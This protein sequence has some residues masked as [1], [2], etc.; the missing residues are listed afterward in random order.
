MLLREDK[1]MDDWLTDSHNI[2]DIIH[3]V[4]PYNGLEAKIIGSATFARLQR[5][6]QSSLAY[7]IY[8]S[9]KV[10]RYEHSIGVMYL[11]GK[12]F[13]HSISNSDEKDVNRLFDEIYK[14]LLNWVDK[15]A[16][17]LTDEVVTDVKNNLDE[18][19]KPSEKVEFK[20]ID[21]R[22]YCEN[23]PSNLAVNQL[24]L[25]YMTYE[26]IR[27]SGL[28]H[29]IGHLPYSHITEF[30]LKRLYVE[31]NDYLKEGNKTNSRI[32]EFIRV[33][34]PYCDKNT[35]KQIHEEV[36][37]KL[38]NKLF[39][40]VMDYIP[41]KGATRENL[42]LAGVFHLTEAILKSEPKDNNILSDLH[43]IID[44]VIDC[45]RMDYCC[46]DLYCAGISKEL[47]RYERIF[48]TVKLF[49]K[50][51]QADKE[52]DNKENNERERCNFS[53]NS[54]ALGQIEMLL[55]SRWEDFSTINYHHSVHKN[56]LL[57]EL[58]ITRL[59]KKYLMEKKK[60]KEKDWILPF[61]ISSI[62]NVIKATGENGAVEIACSQ[63]D[64]EWLNTLLRR[65]YFDKYGESYQSRMDHC[66]DVEWNILDELIT[67]QKHY[68]SLFK[69]NGGFSRFD[70]DFYKACKSIKLDEI[71]GLDKIEKGDTE[72]YFS[73]FI[74]KINKAGMSSTDYFSIVSN[75][76]QEYYCENNPKDNVLNCIIDETDFSLGIKPS[77]M[78]S[79]YIVSSKNNKDWSPLRGRSSIF[80][81]LKMQKDL[82]PQFH[83]YYLPTYDVRHNEIFGV[84]TDNLQKQVARIMA[85][86]M[87][88][89]ICN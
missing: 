46:R 24:F 17:N 81:N 60:T 42:F 52:V 80:D 11:A 58:A 69:R 74:K 72:Y 79:I 36:G 21:N 62:W 41:R 48:Y 57:L 87:K 7:M 71:I 31:I 29:D 67:G 39:S 77:D 20:C 53:F 51:M 63:L 28:L 26:A 1:M 89:V 25:Y 34:S 78:E 75:K 13:F 88:E 65:V 4:V 50:T 9:N 23:T 70:E 2:V 33:M 59:G 6:M 8:P 56:E 37:R 18:F 38:V 16:E 43:R 66:N 5:V 61:E 64:D 49:Y 73:V 54:K 44:G 86:T 27:L 10:H 35:K 12:F 55:L 14:V 40:S 68:W 47:P 3:N 30:A 19:F 85:E 32:D 15:D 22:V 45:D 82:F 76:L 84:D 83:I